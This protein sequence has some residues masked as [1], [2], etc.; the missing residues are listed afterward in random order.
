[1]PIT[2]KSGRQSIAVSYVD[3]LATN[4][5]AT[6]IGTANTSTKAAI[7]L[8]ANSV[9]TRGGLIV[10]T[11][12][13]TEGIRANGVLTSTAAPADTNTV[14]IGSQVYT[15]KTAL[16]ASTTAYEVLIGADEAASLANL[17]AAINLG[18]GSGTKYGSL[19]PVNTTVTAVTDGV[20]T[21]TVTSKV[22]SAANDAVATTETHANAT[23]G[24]A[25]LVDYVVP[26]DTLTVKVGSETYLTA[27]TVDA[28]GFTSLVPTGTLF[29]APTTVDLVWD[30]AN[31]TTVAP[32]DGAVT[33]FV[34]YF[35]LNRSAFNEG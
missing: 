11:A 18:A 17:T 1:M 22:A 23:W 29:T 16:T 6:I 19:T 21:M 13:N 2:K 9:I 27:T 32:T 7:N 3:V 26:A 20:H 15:F 33:L 12:W 10:T 30:V 25:T 8:P 14:T 5:D 28:T 4:F 34:D 24:G 35:I 31:N